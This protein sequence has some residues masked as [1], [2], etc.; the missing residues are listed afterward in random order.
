MNRIRLALAAAFVFFLVF[1]LF[2]C[3]SLP[4]PDSVTLIPIKIV[5]DR[6][7]D[8]RFYL[9]AR[10]ARHTI[11]LIPAKATRYRY[12]DQRDIPADGCISI[13]AHI[14]ALGD[15]VSYE[16]CIRRGETIDVAL[17]ENAAASWAVPRR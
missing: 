14:V 1:S 17:E 8:A 5:N 9:V 2:G 4:T 7:E 13:G 10:G 16:F 11:D 12:V 6:W 3:A 15:W